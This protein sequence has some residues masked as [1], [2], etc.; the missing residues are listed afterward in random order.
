MLEWEHNERFQSKVE[1]FRRH[2]QIGLLSFDTPS[3][4][5]SEGISQQ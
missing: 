4:D 2:N 1:Q 3:G 5:Q